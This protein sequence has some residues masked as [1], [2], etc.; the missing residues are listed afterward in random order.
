MLPRVAYSQNNIV[1]P[2]HAKQTDTRTRACKAQIDL[3]LSEEWSVG[4]AAMVYSVDA[5]VTYL[6][7]VCSMNDLG[8]VS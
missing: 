8:P 5:S 3:T 2:R 7:E 4:C 6:Q 1:C